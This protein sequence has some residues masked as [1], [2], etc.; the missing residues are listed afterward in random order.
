[1]IL[2]VTDFGPQGPYLTQM[3]A[4]LRREAPGVTVLDLF[5][6]APAFNARA[7]AYLMTAYVDEFPT[8]T[9]FLC[10]VDPGVG[11]AR[12]AVVVRAGRRWFV[13][14]DNGLMAIV[15]RRA[16]DAQAWRIDWQPAHLSAS[17]HGRDL[18]APVAGRLASGDLPPGRPV[19]P[20]TLLGHDWPEELHEVV[21]IDHY[22][23]AMTGVR[24]A[25]VPDN[26]TVTIAG[27]TLVRARPFSDVPVGTPFWYDNAN[28]LLEIAVNQGR[29]DTALAATAGTPITIAGPA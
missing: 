6:D 28:G 17:F 22:G 13:G 18:F 3:K 4:V 15:A 21:Y 7:S 19:D 8:E 12:D 29:A 16:G 11:G 23:N 9:V 26:A 2:T 1:M 14:P 24:A 10:V 25:T 20:A 27:R 5:S